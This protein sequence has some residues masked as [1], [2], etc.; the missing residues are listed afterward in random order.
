MKKPFGY[1]PYGSH[2]AVC[3]NVKLHPSVNAKEE[4]SPFHMM[5]VCALRTTNNLSRV[6]GILHGNVLSTF[7]EM[8]HR[9]KLESKIA[10]MKDELTQATNHSNSFPMGNENLGGDPRDYVDHDDLPF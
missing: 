9:L 6:E 7:I 4:L 10:F 2:F 1:T 8:L 3:L 5:G